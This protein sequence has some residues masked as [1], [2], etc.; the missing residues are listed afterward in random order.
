MHKGLCEDD[1]GDAGFAL[2]EPEDDDGHAGFA[3]H[4]PEDDD[5]DAA[6]DLST[7][8]RWSMAINGITSSLVHAC[9]VLSL[10]LNRFSYHCFLF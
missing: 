2:H 4:E 1:D 9:T 3:L 5:G 6:F 10:P 8:L 7:T